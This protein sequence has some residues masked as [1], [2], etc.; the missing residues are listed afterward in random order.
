MR[1]GVGVNRRRFFILT[2][3]EIGNKTVACWCRSVVGHD[4]P[5]DQFLWGHT[6]RLM[7]RCGGPET[8]SITGDA[9][10]LK[11]VTAFALFS[12][13][14]LRRGILSPARMIKM[15]PAA[16]SAND[17][18]ITSRSAQISHHSK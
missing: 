17:K 8:L 6:P 10:R 16:L 2:H 7:S 9:A 18:E 12:T 15:L 14:I 11:K 13:P 4:T 5:E 1:V 3:R